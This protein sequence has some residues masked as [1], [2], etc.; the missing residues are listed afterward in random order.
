[1]TRE[2]VTMSE[3]ETLTAQYIASLQARI[4]FNDEGQRSELVSVEA[5]SL[6]KLMGFI[7][8]DQYS[9]YASFLVDE[10]SQVLLQLENDRKHQ[11]EAQR[12][13]DELMSMEM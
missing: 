4:S 10:C 2:E 1:M 11:E 7:A 13:L 8:P 12:L 9:E 6:E 3:V 5:D